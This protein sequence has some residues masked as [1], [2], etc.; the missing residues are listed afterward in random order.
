MTDLPK[1]SGDHS[2]YYQ[3]RYLT[4]AQICALD[5]ELIKKR[6]QEKVQTGTAVALIPDYKTIGMLVQ[7]CFV[8]VLHVNIIQNGIMR[9]KS[10]WPTN[11]S[12][13]LLT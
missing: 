9:E 3:H 12:E 11:Y 6:L 7:V 13:K 4:S 2:D 1:V 8:F 10:S 5:E